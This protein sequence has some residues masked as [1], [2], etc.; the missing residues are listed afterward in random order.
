VTTEARVPTLRAQ[1]FYFGGIEVVDLVTIGPDA[2]V[3]QQA[4][5]LERFFDRLAMGRA[6]S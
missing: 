2:R 5:V 1:L 6:G 4:V 3:A